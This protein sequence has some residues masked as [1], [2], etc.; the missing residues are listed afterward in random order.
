MH[1]KTRIVHTQN[2]DPWRNLAKEE[3]LLD[4]VEKGEC[5]LYL[6]QNQNTVVIGKNQNP[7]RE[8]STE[9]LEEEGGKLARRLSGGGAVF[10]DLGNL[11]FTFVVD[12]QAY[13]L[14][15]QLEVILSAVRKAGIPAEFS[16]RNDLVAG[17]RKFSGNAFC[18]RKNSAYHHGTIMVSADLEK[19][20]RYLQVSREK[21]QSKGVQSVQSRV[22]NLSEYQPSLTI[23]G[24]V[25]LLIESFR[26]I[27]G[28]NPPISYDEEGMDVAALDR[29]YEKYASWEW[30]YGES[31]KFDIH[32]E[33][34]FPWGGI[35]LGLNLK[36]GR[37]EKASVYSD[38]MDEEFIGMLP[39]ALKG[40]A[41]HTHSL[42]EA[43]RRTSDDPSHKQMIK[44]IAQWL[45]N[46]EF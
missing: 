32:L 45:E 3:Y 6:W 33:T 14:H 7:W 38:A 42:A 36:N 25:E 35:E 2:V 18:F 17:G 5:I 24:M 23:N 22:V 9:L 41:F 4:H 8:C 13:D 43:V 15:R 19:L 44:D 21:M 46:K 12:R 27:Y 37:V 1:L 30:R 20:T 31:P 40:S 26:E 10:H 11:N 28:G 16:G 29:L 39:D 34:R